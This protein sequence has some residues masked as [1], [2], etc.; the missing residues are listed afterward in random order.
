MKKKTKNPDNNNESKDTGID[1]SFDDVENE[2]DKI[3]GTSDKGKKEKPK[4][5][6]ITEK[7][8]MCIEIKHNLPDKDFLK[9]KVE[10]GKVKFTDRYGQKHEKDKVI[11]TSKDI[12]DVEHVEI[13]DGLFS[14]DFRN[15]CNFWFNRS[16]VVVPSMINQAVHTYDD[17]KKCYEME[18][19]KFE[20]P[21]VLILALVG[22]AVVILL[23]LWSLFG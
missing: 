6:H 15:D 21:I 20:I 3:L 4:L 7:I 18:K 10:R 5:H 16:P 17:I 12:N 2:V 9:V 23:M 1:F 22:G 8:Q 14:M 11:V 19:R 13:T